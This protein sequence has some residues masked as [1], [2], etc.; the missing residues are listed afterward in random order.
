MCPPVGLLPLGIP[1]TTR[2]GEVRSSPDPHRLGTLPPAG[3]SFERL[4]RS[5][6]AVPPFCIPSTPCVWS[7][8]QSGGRQ[9]TEERDDPGGDP[10]PRRRPVRGRCMGGRH[11][12]PLAVP[13]RVAT[14]SWGCGLP[15]PTRTTS[16]CLGAGA[17]RLRHFARRRADPRCARPRAVLP[18]AD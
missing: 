14:A 17:A 12:P 7:S 15:P 9:R 18:S 8:A 6:V 5:P 4:R 3:L 1:R 2:Q 16:P 11:R 10:P 13:A